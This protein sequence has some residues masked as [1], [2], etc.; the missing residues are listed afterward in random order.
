MAHTHVHTHLGHVVDVAPHH[1]PGVLRDE[2]LLDG[3]QQGQSQ[4]LG[5]VEGRAGRLVEREG[6]A[7]LVVLYVYIGAGGAG[8]IAWPTTKFC[9]FATHV[10]Q[11]DKKNAPRIFS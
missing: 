1:H 7:C 9:T 6:E 3:A 4:K 2:A 8:A 10:D 11:K 5:V